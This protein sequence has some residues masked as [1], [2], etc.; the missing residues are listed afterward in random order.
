MFLHLEH[1]F[2]SSHVAQFAVLVFVFVMLHQIYRV[3][4][5]RSGLLDGVLIFPERSGV[6][7]RSRIGA[8]Q[9]GIGFGNHFHNSSAF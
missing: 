6:Y 8:V 7:I 1:M 3:I 5:Y 9:G 4:L 2:C